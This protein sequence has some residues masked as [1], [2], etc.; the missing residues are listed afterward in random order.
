MDYLEK[1]EEKINGFKSQSRDVEV[2][3]VAEFLYHRLVAAE[4]ALLVLYAG[5]QTVHENGAERKILDI[6]DKA[7]DPTRLPIKLQEI[8]G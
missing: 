5:M 3:K 2:T 7:L 8:T 6:A 4:Y 1:I